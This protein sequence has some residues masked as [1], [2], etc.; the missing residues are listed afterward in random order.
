MKIA[1][2][3]KLSEN[4]NS[5]FFELEFKIESSI[6]EETRYVIIDNSCDHRQLC[7]E[8]SYVK[9]ISVD[10]VVDKSNFL[11]LNGVLILDED[12]LLSSYGIMYLKRFFTST[13]SIHFLE[14]FKSV[15]SDE[16]SFKI[17][18]FGVTGVYSDKVYSYFQDRDFNKVKA[19]LV[20]STM[21]SLFSSIEESIRFPIEFE[22]GS[23]DH[24]VGLNFSMSSDE[25]SISD[26]KL[27]YVDFINMISQ[28]CSFVEVSYINELSKINLSIVID[29]NEDVNTCVSFID[30]ANIREKR[31]EIRF[32]PSLGSFLKEKIKEVEQEEEVTVFTSELDEVD[33]KTLPPDKLKEEV[34]TKIKNE[35]G[36]SADDDTEVP[37]DYLE[38]EAS[39]VIKG[40]SDEKDQVQT[41]KSLKEEDKKFVSTVSSS[42]DEKDFALKISS[43]FNNEMKNEMMRVQSTGENFD[44]N[45]VMTTIISKSQNDGLI[46]EESKEYIASL[47]QEELT[48]KVMSLVNFSSNDHD[49]L[50]IEKLTK[51][52]KIFKQ[53]AFKFE[54]EAKILS[55]EVKK[56][57]SLFR[58]EYLKLE[59]QV[60]AKEKI[61]HKFKETLINVSK[62]KD[63]EIMDLKTNIDNLSNAKTKDSNIQ[64][65]SQL[66]RSSKIEEHL[67][68]KLDQEK[69]NSRSMISEVSKAKLAIKEAQAK[70]QGLASYI[71]KLE[72]SVATL[73]KDKVDLSK[74]STK[75]NAVGARERKLELSLR[76]MQMEIKKSRVGS[77]EL[78]KKYIKL[79]NENTALQNQIDRSKS[80]K[81]A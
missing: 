20:F 54:K 15:Y 23:N 50:I 35:S 41:I 42:S 73:K 19:R 51:R 45:K 59:R 47:S 56:S 74:S 64:N 22:L 29:E 30:I 25:I 21:I 9:F 79:K 13:P 55:I 6:T 48:E 7:Q 53:K 77:V 31:K 5:F 18:S 40:G 76:K 4:I 71:K 60:S 44:M 34:L 72:L 37:E 65:N 11:S 24:S 61:A 3:V 57:E 27:K 69:K 78:K 36:Q 81:A 26:F 70:Q 12:Q 1:S 75:Q 68:R 14:D 8:Y 17:S 32:T 33:Y 67:I 52:E 80:K 10:Q 49:K 62:Q 16:L 39:E 2:L 66:K 63:K 43:S 58:S 38:K 46:K 28:H